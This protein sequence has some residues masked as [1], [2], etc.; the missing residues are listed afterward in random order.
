MLKA[1]YR[2]L[3][4]CVSDAP[5]PLLCP[6]TSL[7]PRPPCGWCH[8]HCQGVRNLRPRWPSQGLLTAGLLS[9]GQL[10]VFLSV[11]SETAHL[12]HWWQE[13][14]HLHGH[15][16][17]HGGQVEGGATSW[18]ASQGTWYRGKSLHLR[19]NFPYALLSPC[20]PL[21]LHLPTFFFGAHR[22]V[23]PWCP[24]P[25]SVY[26]PCHSLPLRLRVSDSINRATSFFS[27][28]AGFNLSAL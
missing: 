1:N 15:L 12:A 5:S 20:I 19:E 6:G 25:C 28:I 16:L 11:R 4:I 24:W 3:C 22:R 17:A 26:S 14:W 7:L 8:P 27:S 23:V 18:L 13:R 2:H 21:D 10:R 9:R